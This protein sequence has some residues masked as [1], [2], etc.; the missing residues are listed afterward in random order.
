[1]EGISLVGGTSAVFFITIVSNVYANVSPNISFKSNVTFGKQELGIQNGHGD[2]FSWVQRVDGLENWEKNLQLGN[3]YIKTSAA[4]ESSRAKFTLGL[5]ALHNFMY[6]QAVEL[7]TSALNNERQKANK[8]FPMANWG[9][10]MASKYMFW[11]SSNCQL[12]K[13]AVVDI[14]ENYKDQVTDKEASFIAMAF[15]LFPPNKECKDDTEDER[16]NRF[17]E[18][19][20]ENLNKIQVI[21]KAHFSMV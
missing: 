10:A 8:D 9:I 20:L 17:T 16:D 18:A 13:K 14:P 15:A 2:V 12:G 21:L 3:A 5:L 19:A 11:S 6:D 4:L 7:F 1:M